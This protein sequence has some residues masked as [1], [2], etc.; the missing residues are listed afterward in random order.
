MISSQILNRQLRRLPVKGADASEIA[1]EIR[2]WKYI[3]VFRK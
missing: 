2:E 3:T 1:K